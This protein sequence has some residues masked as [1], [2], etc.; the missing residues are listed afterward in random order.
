MGFRSSSEHIENMVIAFVT[1]NGG[2]VGVVNFA[3]RAFPPKKYFFLQPCFSPFFFFLS[4]VGALCSG[5]L[6]VAFSSTSS[7]VGTSSFE[8][9]GG[10]HCNGTELVCS[11]LNSLGRL[12]YPAVLGVWALTQVTSSSLLSSVALFRFGA[13]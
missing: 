11:S 5:T 12:Q 2:M 10:V 8:A 4:F 9:L 7:Y 3:P 6:F 13:S 1:C